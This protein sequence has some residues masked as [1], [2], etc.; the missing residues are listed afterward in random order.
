MMCDATGTVEGVKNSIQEVI[1]DTLPGEVNQQGRPYAKYF[2]IPVRPEADDSN[3]LKDS[4]TFL[5]L[6]KKIGDDA[7]IVR[8]DVIRSNWVIGGLIHN[9]VISERWARLL[10]NRLMSPRDGW[11]MY[12]RLLLNRFWTED[13]IR[14]RA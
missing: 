6:A 2:M 8:E 9:L 4:E 13:I 12:G 7:T 5:N 10:V 14:N 11:G 1:K 3:A